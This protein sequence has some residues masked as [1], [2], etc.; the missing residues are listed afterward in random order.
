MKPLLYKSVVLF[1]IASIS[2]CAQEKVLYNDS[3][4]AKSI[5]VIDLDLRNIPIQILPSLD[6]RI[7]IQLSVNYKNFS[8]KEF[9]KIFPKVTV[10]KHQNQNVLNLKIVSDKTIPT[11][12]YASN[13]D[14]KI[15]DSKLFKNKKKS[16][17]FKRKTKQEIISEIAINTLKEESILGVLFK[18]VEEDKKA[19][20][21]RPKFILLIPKDKT[22]KI[23]AYGTQIKLEQDQVNQLTL[24]MN[25]GGFTARK[26]LS[27]KITIN[28]APL[29]VEQIDNGNVALKDGGNSLIGSIS[30]TTLK[31]E[32][33]F[34]KVGL[35][36][37]KVK[38]NDFNSEI[39]LYNF[40]S[41]FH[42]FHF[43]GDYSKIHFYEPTD[44]YGM[45]VFGNNTTFYFDKNS[46]ISQ[47]TKSNKKSK[48]MDRKP[49]KNNPSGF[50]NF[51]I[52]HSIFY[53]PTSIIINKQVP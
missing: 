7:S 32:A 19:K 16:D 2:L 43:T 36:G 41:K 9:Q 18:K 30:K 50:I 49:K 44:D 34:L 12:Y 35:I 13:I 53:Y 27:P 23:N 40:S 22:I 21:Y 29:R 5:S 46:I 20:N 51:E 15:D 17:K 33:T 25:K 8:K 28:N 37:N 3:F 4:D 39:Y 1:F 52:T 26:L 11:T 10:K 31:T 47:P 42:E 24:N 48:M 14:L 45:N 6:T 38:F